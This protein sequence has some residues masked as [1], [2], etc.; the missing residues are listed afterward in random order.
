M[1]LPITPTPIHPTR[2]SA[3][4]IADFRAPAIT[5]R[6]RSSAAVRALSLQPCAH[7]RADEVGALVFDFGTHTVKAGY[8]GEDAPKVRN[9]QAHS[10]PNRPRDAHNPC[11]TSSRRSLA[12]TCWRRAWT[13]LQTACAAPCKLL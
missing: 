6:A 4:A 7:G 9:L 2:S 5:C 10:A 8:A 12:T 3:A 1:D 11:S 13:R